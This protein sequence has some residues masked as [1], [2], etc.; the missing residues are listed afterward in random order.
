[1]NFTNTHFKKIII[2]LLLFLLFTFSLYAFVEF[3]VND[4]A[5]TT[6]NDKWTLTWSIWVV[7]I[8]NPE[9]TSL[10]LRWELS[11][12]I[13]SQ[14]FWRFYFTKLDL[15]EDIPV[16]TECSEW[17]TYSFSWIIKSDFYWDMNVVNNLS[18]YC[19]ELDDF[20]L[21]VNSSKLWE[22]KLTQ[23][24][25]WIMVPFNIFDKKEI[26]ISWLTSLTW[27]KSNILDWWWNEINEIYV[28]L[29]KKT[30]LKTQINKN[31]AY[32]TKFLEPENNKTLN[33]ISWV[34]CNN[35]N[36]EIDELEN[37]VDFDK[38]YYFNFNWI[39]WDD[40]WY[41]NE[42]KNLI[43]SNWNFSSSDPESYKIWVKWKNTVIVEW[44][45]IYINAD[46]SND[47]DSNDILVLVAKRDL[48]N[49]NNWWN[50][51]IN[52]NVTNIDATI[53]ADWSILN[54]DWTNIKSIK[55]WDTE[56]LRRQFYIY[57]SL[58]SS[59][60]I[61]TNEVPYWSDAYIQLDYSMEDN[62]YDLTK[63]RTFQSR[64]ANWSWSI[65]C[66]WNPNFWVWYS[67]IQ[68][69]WIKDYAWAWKSKC[70]NKNINPTAINDST[71]VANLRTTD[72]FN[73]VIIDYNSNLYK[74]SPLIIKDN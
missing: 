72:K 59:N 18:Y 29:G 39:T 40:N 66:W 7:P 27:E 12:N 11:W 47:D 17:E 20:I 26:A 57:G 13:E 24:I 49:Q 1:M 61:W 60:V 67:W 56:V 15:I 31:I 32:I 16:R 10:G 2:F 64:Y 46:I 38:I 71:P 6:W 55:N 69:D 33:F 53:I 4:D 52:P 21:V 5:N 41:W 44:W 37:N 19:P 28:D 22:K 8:S 35:D 34:F 63:L 9:Y 3:Y 58:L 14:L 54:F 36:C 74:I 42:W 70:F 68:V 62:I 23:N 65:L 43:I 50:V 51:Y 73:S 45:N 30:I 25:S 48:N